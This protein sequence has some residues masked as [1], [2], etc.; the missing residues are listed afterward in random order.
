M[1]LPPTRLLWTLVDS[2][3]GLE[4]NQLHWSSPIGV[5]AQLKKMNV[6][7]WNQTQILVSLAHAITSYAMQ[8]QLP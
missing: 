2:S 5:L 6:T 3:H 8:P 4:S 7:S 1:E